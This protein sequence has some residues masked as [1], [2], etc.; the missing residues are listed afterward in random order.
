[1]K[2]IGMIAVVMM[3]SRLRAMWR[4]D[5]PSRT[6]VSPKNCTVILSPL[7]RAAVSDQR[8]EDVLERGL[9]LDVLD[10][11]RRQQPLELAERPVHDD[12]PPVEDRDAIRE[13][14][15]LVQVLRREQH[16]GALP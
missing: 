9:L 4:R 15:G 12:A 14:L 6:Q 13:L 10:L 8:E 2:A 1:M 5:R 3:V 11:G 16:R 7:H